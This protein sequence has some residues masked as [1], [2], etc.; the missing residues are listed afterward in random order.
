MKLYTIFYIWNSHER[1]AVLTAFDAASAVK[2]WLSK[3][4]G[5]P[6][7]GVMDEAGK[8][9]VSC[10]YCRCDL[11]Y[12]ANPSVMY[13]AVVRSR[14]TFSCRGCAQRW[15]ADVKDGGWS[16]KIWPHNDQPRELTP[17][18]QHSLAC[19]VAAGGKV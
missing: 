18:E 13:E 7:T 16:G 15:F 6:I 9:I 17:E 14:R 12:G 1:R 8:Q 11:D 10:S 4:P 3:Y 5:L 19:D 2:E